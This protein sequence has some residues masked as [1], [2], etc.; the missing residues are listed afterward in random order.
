MILPGGETIPG[1]R[2]MGHVAVW[3]RWLVPSMAF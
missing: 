2:L 1:R 3:G